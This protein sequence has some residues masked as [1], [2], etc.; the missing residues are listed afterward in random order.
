MSR[1]SS[2]NLLMKIVM[3]LVLS[4]YSFQYV[5]H[6]SM[7]PGLS[8]RSYH[9]IPHI[10]MLLPEIVMSLL[11]SCFVS[12]CIILSCLISVTMHSSYHSAPIISSGTIIH[13]S[14][15]QPTFP[16]SLL[17]VRHRGELGRVKNRWTDTTRLQVPIFTC[18]CPT[19]LK[20]RGTVEKKRCILSVMWVVVC[21]REWVIC[22]Q[23]DWCEMQPGMPE[24][25]AR[26]LRWGQG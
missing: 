1:T 12:T 11:L 3:L 25:L 26:R 14:D 13:L 7:L 21:A 2:S 22:G 8:C 23:F 15:P 16:P 18:L 6:T 20:I 5:A 17:L 9:H 10:V 24:S 4:W 19:R